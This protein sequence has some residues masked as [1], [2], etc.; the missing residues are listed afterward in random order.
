MWR[1]GGDGRIGVHKVPHVDIA[2]GDDAVEWG[3]RNAPSPNCAC[4]RSGLGRESVIA[5]PEHLK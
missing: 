5:N 1:R 4:H 2:L 3:D